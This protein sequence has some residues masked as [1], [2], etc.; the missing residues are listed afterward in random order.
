M[1]GLIPGSGVYQAERLEREKIAGNDVEDKHHGRPGVG[2]S[3]DRELVEPIVSG[4]SAV[5]VEDD[6]RVGKETMEDEDNDRRIATESIECG[7][8]AG[9]AFFRY[10]PSTG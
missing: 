6:R 9:M 1:E 10:L 8:C 7:D 5:T 3:H 4:T 2:E